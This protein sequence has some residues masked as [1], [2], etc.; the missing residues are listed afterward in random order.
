M[1]THTLPPFLVFGDLHGRILPAFRFASYW[2]RQHD[3]PLSGLL[4]V[5]DLGF[6]PDI[7]R[8][9]KATLRH[10]E[11]DPLELGSVDVITRNDLADRTFDDDP[12][13]P[14]GLWFTAGNHEDFH[15]LEHLAQCTGNNPD[16]PVDAYG[17][18]WGVKDGAVVPL[19]KPTARWDSPTD[20]NSTA[21]EPSPLRIGAIWGV[22]GSGANSRRKLPPR[23]YI[24]EAAVHRLA[25]EQ[26]DVL[27]SHDA[28]F[29]GKRVGYGSRLLS[30]LIEQTSPRF[31][32]F[33][34]YSGE[35]SRSL[36]DFGPTEVYHLAG[37]EMRTRDGRPESGSVGV[38]QNAG[39]GW[40]FDFVPDEVLKPFTRH[41]WKWV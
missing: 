22:D 39:S 40:T 12:A 35:G 41:N 26:F 16:F 21:P 6:F 24:D 37:F 36:A 13:C 18:V 38:L 34:H 3:Q 17:R 9:D 31:A 2:S 8:L 25:W 15:Q 30:A 4:Q 10:A 19:P 32:F 29:E 28:P 20:L 27:L 33:G 14:P 23:G 11:D 1:E 7:S 5:G